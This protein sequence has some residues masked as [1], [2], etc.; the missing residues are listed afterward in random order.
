MT[1]TVPLSDLQPIPAPG[2][3]RV[4]LAD[5][6]PMPIKPFISPS[7]DFATPTVMGQPGGG[8]LPAPAPMEPPVTSP[9][10][11]EAPIAQNAVPPSSPAAP[12]PTKTEIVTE[13]TPHPPTASQPTVPE[14]P[15]TYALQTQQLAGGDR[16][17]VMLP[18]GEMWRPGQYPQHVRLTADKFGNVYM[19]RAD[20]ITRSEVKRAAANN[21]LPDV[22]GHATLGMGTEDKTLLQA[23]LPTVKGTTPEGTEAQSAVTDA[24]HLPATLLA[25]HA[26][27]PPGGTVNV[28][29]PEQ[30]VADRQ[31]QPAPTGPEFFRG[32]W[33]V[34]LTAKGLQDARDVAQRTAGQF[35]EIHAS[36]L[37]RAHA[38]AQEVAHSNP[39][40]G[41]VQTEPALRPMALG[42]HEGEEVTPERSDALNAQLALRPKEPLPGVGKLS[43]QPGD[44]FNAWKGPLIA[45]IERQWARFQPGDRILN[46]THYR[47]VQALKAWEKAGFPRNRGVDIGEMVQKGEQKPGDLYRLDPHMGAITEAPDASQDGIYFLRHGETEANN[48]NAAVPRELQAGGQ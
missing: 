1:A 4:S 42:V 38:T 47:D 44:S 19:Y 12:K 39:Q 26:V 46:V 3:A 40:A 31:G 18:K 7:A 28:Q 45:H 13:A 9:I 16:R 33:D 35:T 24:A 43:G 17:V 41:P 22:L 6:Q 25:T 10:T 32:A 36:P 2:T 5:L 15:E 30:V 27:T 21:E 8:A 48:T 37:N 14:T 11:P 23:P 29:S 20:L 34:P